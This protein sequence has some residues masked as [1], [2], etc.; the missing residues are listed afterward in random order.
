MLDGTKKSHENHIYL[1]AELHGEFQL[2]IEISGIRKLNECLFRNTGL[3]IA[4][5]FCKQVSVRF[6]S[7]HSIDPIITVEGYDK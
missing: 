3:E 7:T 1:L 2:G 6:V 5:A 4:G